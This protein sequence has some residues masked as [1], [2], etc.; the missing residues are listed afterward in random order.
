[1]PDR[2]TV[3]SGR[4]SKTWSFEMVGQRTPSFCPCKSLIPNGQKCQKS[5]IRSA[6]ISRFDPVHGKYLRGSEPGLLPPEMAHFLEPENRQSAEKGYPDFCWRLTA[7]FESPSGGAS[8]VVIEITPRRA[9]PV[10]AYL[11]RLVVT[12]KH[13]G[14]AVGALEPFYCLM[15]VIVSVNR[16]PGDSMGA[17]RGKW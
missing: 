1:M 15:R 7:T 8:R 16:S 4:I 9:R 11:L 14:R 10:S 6:P 5:G 12:S 3:A 13:L 2:S 17:L